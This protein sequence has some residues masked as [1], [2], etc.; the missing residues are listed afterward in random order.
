MNALHIVL[1]VM[2]QAF[3]CF[4]PASPI[5]IATA[6]KRMPERIICG[7]ANYDDARRVEASKV[8]WEMQVETVENGSR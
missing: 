2:V 6:S 5:C 1:F 3:L 4:V 7:H 8:C